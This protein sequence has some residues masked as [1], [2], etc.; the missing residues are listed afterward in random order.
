MWLL[1]ALRGGVESA[2]DLGTADWKVIL[3]TPH[4]RNSPDQSRS[5]RY[6]AALGK[7]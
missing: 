3:R 6:G 1:G 5:T 4:A 7:Y 2:Q